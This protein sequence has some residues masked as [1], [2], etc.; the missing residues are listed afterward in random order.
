MTSEEDTY[1]KFDN[2]VKVHKGESSLNRYRDQGLR[3]RRHGSS[4]IK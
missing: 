3:E 4:E 2:Y 1:T